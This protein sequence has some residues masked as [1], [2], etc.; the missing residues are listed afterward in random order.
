MDFSENKTVVETLSAGKT[1]QLGKS[2]SRKVISKK[3]TEKRPLFISLR[4]DLGAGKTAIVRGMLKGLGYTGDV[5]S[6]T[7]SLC[8]RYS[9][10][11]LNCYH[12]DLYRLADEDE[13][14]AAGL[15]EFDDADV[16][17][18][19]WP[20]IALKSYRFDYDIF[21]QY[22]DNPKKRII[23]IRDLKDGEID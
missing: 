4:G 6:P 23:E 18:V 16:V 5:T 19:E 12:L 2:F 11:N 10:K 14:F 7:F 9:I 1:E 15:T 20:E 22:G 21:I 13:L 17:F 3:V 8:N